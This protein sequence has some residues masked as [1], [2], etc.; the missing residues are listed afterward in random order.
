MYFL[1]YLEGAVA[2]S[3]ILGPPGFKLLNS[4]P[5]SPSLFLPEL[6]PLSP[7][8]FLFFTF[9]VFFFLRTVATGQRAYKNLSLASFSPAARE[10][11]LLPSP[12]PLVSLLPSPSSRSNQ[13]LFPSILLSHH[14]LPFCLHAPGH[15]I[16]VFRLSSILFPFEKLFINPLRRISLILSLCL[17]FKE[18]LDDFGP[19]PFCNLFPLYLR[20]LLHA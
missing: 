9:L 16:D 20:F 17:L 19:S 4:W 11:R 1:W 15:F 14:F 18:R 13:I 10:L 6:L 3:H 2:D 8:Y 7:P 12:R 5:V